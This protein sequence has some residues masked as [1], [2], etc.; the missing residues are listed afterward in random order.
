MKKPVDF[1]RRKPKQARSQGTVDSILEAAIQLLQRDGAHGLNTNRVAERAGVSIGT[2]YQYFPDKEAILLAVARRELAKADTGLAVLQKNLMEALARALESFL[3]GGAV[4]AD[5]RT[6]TPR[7]PVKNGRNPGTRRIVSLVEDFVLT[8][9]MPPRLAPNM[10][11]A[12]SRRQ[13]VAR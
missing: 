7:V 2:L 1:Q 8:W 13:R 12:M 4:R 9:V 11:P 5:R 3:G 6:R 10:L